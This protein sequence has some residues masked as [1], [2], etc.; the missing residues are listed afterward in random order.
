M[1][2]MLLCSKFKGKLYTDDV[3]VKVSNL[4]F[5]AFIYKHLNSILNAPD[6]FCVLYSYQFHF[7]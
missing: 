6:T 5:C 1:V 7:K 2:I 4:N 3:L